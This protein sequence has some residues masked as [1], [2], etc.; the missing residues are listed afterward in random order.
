MSDINQPMYRVCITLAGV[1]VMNFDITDMDV[2]LDKTYNCIDALPN[3]IKERLAVLMM[4][5]PTPP[6]DPVDGIGRRI[7]ENIFWVTV[8]SKGERNE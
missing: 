8:P 5:S 6:T 3:W 7:S 4:T 2:C 1:S